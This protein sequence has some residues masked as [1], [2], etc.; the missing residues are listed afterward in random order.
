M[1]VLY[2]W[3]V[4]LHYSIKNSFKNF[5]AKYKYRDLLLPSNYICCWVRIYSYT[6]EFL[7]VMKNFNKKA[8]KFLTI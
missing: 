2:M 4:V 5:T 7:Q 8:D 1:G 6:R 3:V